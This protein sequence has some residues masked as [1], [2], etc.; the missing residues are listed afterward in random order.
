[1]GKKK[2]NSWSLYDMTGN[3]QEWCNDTWNKLAYQMCGSITSD[4][5]EYQSYSRSHVIRGG[6]WFHIENDCRTASRDC[7]SSNGHLNRLGLR[8]IKPVIE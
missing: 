1:M 5:L 2:P 4:P 7:C 3:I 6:S 8:I